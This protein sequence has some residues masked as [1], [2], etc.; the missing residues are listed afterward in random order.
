MWTAGIWFASLGTGSAVVTL[1]ASGGVTDFGEPSTF[2][3]SF[4]LPSAESWPPGSLMG[5]S[6]TVEA[7]DVLDSMDGTA[8]VLSVAPDS[9]YVARINGIVQ[10]ELLMDPFNLTVS[11]PGGSEVFTASFSGVTNTA[12]APLGIA[13]LLTSGSQPWEV[14][15]WRASQP[16]L[17]WGFPNRAAC[18]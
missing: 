18:C 15:I 3:F 13:W 1:T 14:A 12:L 17:S 8:S 9:V 5:G 16:S 6:V 11:A 7:Q 4:S 10:E 2:G